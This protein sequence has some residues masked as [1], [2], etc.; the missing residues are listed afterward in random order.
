MR[1]AM[2][3]KDPQGPAIA[4]GAQ[5]FL[6]PIYHRMTSLLIG[7]DSFGLGYGKPLAIKNHGDSRLNLHSLYYSA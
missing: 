7:P 3:I 2:L 4:A 5:Q 6:K 1:I